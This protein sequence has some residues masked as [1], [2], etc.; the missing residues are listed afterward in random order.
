MLPVYLQIQL[1]LL[2]LLSNTV[3]GYINLRRTSESIVVAGG[4]VF[5]SNW[6]GGKEVMVINDV[7]DKVADSIQVGAEPES[8]VIDRNGRL[9]VLCNGGYARQNNAEL[10]EINARNQSN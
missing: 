7:N 8:M 4:K 9:W 3:S 10:Y 6:A 2:I 1:Q 5:I